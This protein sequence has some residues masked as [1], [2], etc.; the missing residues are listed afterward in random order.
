MEE[1]PGSRAQVELCR[2]WVPTV[3]AT[4]HRRNP[5]LY[6]VADDVMLWDASGFRPGVS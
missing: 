3:V 4:T 6:E 1:S 2:Q 5:A